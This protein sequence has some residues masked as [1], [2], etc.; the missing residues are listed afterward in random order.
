[1]PTN[2]E[3]GLGSEHRRR[4]AALLPYAYGQTCP[5]FGR[6]DICPGLMQRGEDLDLDHSVP[7]SLGGTVGDRI[8]HASCNR[9]WGNGTRGDRAKPDPG[10]TPGW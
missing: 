2:K 4:R 7:R 1:M 9:S 10:P 6:V 8:A 5:Y 3:R